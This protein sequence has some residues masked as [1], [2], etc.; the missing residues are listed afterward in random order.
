MKRKRIALQLE[1]LGRGGGDLQVHE[2][3]ELS[4]AVA[5][6]ALDVDTGQPPANKARTDREDRFSQVALAWQLATRGGSNPWTNKESKL[7]GG[8]ATAMACLGSYGT[9]SDV[10]LPLLH[11]TPSQPPSQGSLADDQLDGAFVHWLLSALRAEPAKTSVF[12]FSSKFRLQKK[13]NRLTGVGWYDA[14]SRHRFLDQNCPV[15]ILVSGL[16]SS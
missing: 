16:A 7:Q 2:L 13:G 8:T 10:T 3:G 15:W 12:F 6:R 14:K 4:D 9:H 11:M 1:R 5:E